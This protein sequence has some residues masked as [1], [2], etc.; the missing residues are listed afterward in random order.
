MRVLIFGTFDHLHPG[1]LFVF[2]EAR[3]RGDVTIVVARDRN[4]D[5]IK[6]R[7]PNESEGQRMH[8]VQEAFPDAMVILGEA[9]DFLKPVREL[10]PD[11][12]LLGYDQ[13]MPPGIAEEDLGVPIERLSAYRPEEFKSSL[14]ELRIKN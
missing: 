12:I 14:K 11:L 3:K 5:L 8:A 6:G 10:Q 13:R 2:E 7:M 4:V 9:S 1:H